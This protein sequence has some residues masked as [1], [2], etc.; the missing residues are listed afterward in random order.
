MNDN[1]VL[2]EYNNPVVI[3]TGKIYKNEESR[4]TRYVLDYIT[5]F[6]KEKI[7]TSELMALS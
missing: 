6:V 5:P 1:T 3:H 2:D 7:T 4:K